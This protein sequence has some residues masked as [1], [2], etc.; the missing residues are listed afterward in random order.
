MH[1]LLIP[2]Q[3]GGAF[4]AF[5]RYKAGSD[6]AFTQGLGDEDGMGVGGDQSYQ[7]YGEDGGQYGEAPFQ[8][9]DQ[10]GIVTDSPIKIPS[11]LIK[12]YLLINHR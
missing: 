8:G 1:F 4:F 2:F 6:T 10:P 3:A 7:G 5:Q 9:G 11:F 12:Y